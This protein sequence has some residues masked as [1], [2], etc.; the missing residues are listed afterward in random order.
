MTGAVAVMSV[1]KKSGPVIQLPGAGYY[2]ENTVDPFTASISLIA[3]SGGSLDID[4]NVSPDTDL[5]SW[6]SPEGAEPGSLYE[7]RADVTSGVLTSGT[8]GAWLSL[9]SGRTWQK[10]VSGGS[11]SVSLS[12][13]IRRASDQVVLAGPV[14][15]TLNGTVEI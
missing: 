10:N 15:Y 14:T 3:G 11:S 4:R 6:M 8:T 9:G 13:Q 7:I 5:G 1:S 2:E 12:V